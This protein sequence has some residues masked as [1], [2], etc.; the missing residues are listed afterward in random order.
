MSDISSPRGVAL[1]P[2]SLADDPSLFKK[3]EERK[4]DTSKINM[5]KM[6]E[7]WAKMHDEMANKCKSD[8]NNLFYLHYIFCNCNILT[9]LLFSRI[10]RTSDQGRPE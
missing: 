1:R 10:C 8:K 5:S 6:K 2:T 9:T 3:R 4:L 7:V